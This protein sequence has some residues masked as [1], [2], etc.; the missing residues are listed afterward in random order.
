MQRIWAALVPDG[1]EGVQLEQV[2]DRDL[3][4][5]LDIRIGTAD[6]FLVENHGGEASLRSCR[7]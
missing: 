4:L 2:I 7:R 1:C 5:V 3:A 6:R